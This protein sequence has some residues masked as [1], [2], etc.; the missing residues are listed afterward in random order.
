M[1]CHTFVQRVA[2]FS[3][4]IAALCWYAPAY[5]ARS[6]S[7]SL[8]SPSPAEFDMGTT[9]SGTIRIT[10]SGNQDIITKLRFRINNGD[11]F[12]AGVTAPSGWTVTLSSASGGGYNTVTFTATSSANGIAVGGF[13]DFTVPILFRRTTQDTSEHL[14]DIRATF[15]TGSGG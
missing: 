15:T 7:S 6:F 1:R 13:R 14:R 5:A 4:C 9:S 8:V 12:A 10:N 3:I 2:L 11:H